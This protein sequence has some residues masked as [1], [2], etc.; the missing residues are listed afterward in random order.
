MFRRVIL[1]DW[2]MWVPYICFAL[3]FAAFILIVLWAVFLKKSRVDYE[4]RLPL[5][6]DTDLKDITTNQN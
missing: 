1:E 3:T 5:E 4:S 2:H 6:D